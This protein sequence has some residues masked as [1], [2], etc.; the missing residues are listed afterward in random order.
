MAK[1]KRKGPSCTFIP[2]APGTDQASKMYIDLNKFI[3]NRP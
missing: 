3:K 2:D 1:R